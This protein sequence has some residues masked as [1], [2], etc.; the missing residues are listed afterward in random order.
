[1][2]TSNKNPNLHTA[3]AANVLTLNQLSESFSVGSKHGTYTIVGAMCNYFLS[4]ALRKRHCACRTHKTEKKENPGEF[5]A[6]EE[7]S[8]AVVMASVIGLRLCCLS[9]CFG[10]M[11][12]DDLCFGRL[13]L[14]IQQSKWSLKKWRA[15]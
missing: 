1:M 5:G 7:L 6:P 8:G 13:T 10:V 9:S 14:A 2:K 15:F 12:A 3:H 11:R 4:L